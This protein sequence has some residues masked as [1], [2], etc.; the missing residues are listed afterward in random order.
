ML[1]DFEGKSNL[2]DSVNFIN[3]H[4]LFG[5]VEVGEDEKR[6]IQK[7]SYNDI[8]VLEYMFAGVERVLVLFLVLMIQLE[9]RGRKR[10]EGKCEN[11]VA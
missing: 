1:H 4:H 10:V 8:V 7:I 2:L 11:S 6:V 5:D 9:E 3:G